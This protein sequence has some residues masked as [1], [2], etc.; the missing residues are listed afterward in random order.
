M[1]DDVSPRLRWMK[2]LFSFSVSVRSQWWRPVLKLSLPWLLGLWEC[3][4]Q[5]T[6]SVFSGAVVCQRCSF[7]RDKKKRVFYKWHLTLTH[8]PTFVC[9]RVAAISSNTL[10]PSPQVFYNLCWVT[11]PFSP[12]PSTPPLQS[13]PPTLLPSRGHDQLPLH[14]PLQDP[15]VL[16]CHQVKTCCCFFSY[17]ETDTVS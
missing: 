12:H 15:P 4:Q 11:P 17:L 10:C 1:T 2:G 3:H 7:L 16:H 9:G 5:V 13:C 6:D 14:F 8:T